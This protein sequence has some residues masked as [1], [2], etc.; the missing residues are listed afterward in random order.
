VEEDVEPEKPSTPEPVAE[1]EAAALT[2]PAARPEPPALPEPAPVPAGPDRFDLR[3]L[4]A[5]KGGNDEKEWEDGYASNAGNGVV[6]L[7]DGA[8]DGIFSKLWADLLL[9]SFVA[10]PIA[11]DDAAVVEPWIEA[12]RRAWFEA[13]RY[14]EQRWSIQMKIDRSCGAATF[15]ALVLDPVTDPGEDPAAAI[16]WTAWA[17]G[18]ACLFHVRGGQLTASFPVAASSEFG[19][20]PQLYQSKALRQTPLAVVT[21]GELGPDDQIFFATDAVAQRLLA[22]V[23]SGTP[24]D[25]GRFWNL[26]QEA[27]RQELVALRQQNAIVNDDCTLLVVRLPV[28]SPEASERSEASK[29]E[30]P[31]DETTGLDTPFDFADEQPPSPEDDDDSP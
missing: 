18:D 27:W 11:L 19:T 13:I 15:I 12:K 17:V 16:G 5:P 8:G 20:T 25:W 24:P 9:E 10:L 1:S 31:I 30:A 6:A 28:P 4:W 23:E 21:R 14:P 26:D 7:A 22:E 2:D 29:A 3:V